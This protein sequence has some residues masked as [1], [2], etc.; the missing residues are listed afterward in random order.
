MSSKLLYP[1]KAIKLDFQFAMGASIII[2]MADDWNC[3]YE[4]FLQLNILLS[5]GLLLFF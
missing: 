2:K 5:L 3:W 1:L 4:H